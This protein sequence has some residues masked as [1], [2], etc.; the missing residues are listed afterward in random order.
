MRQPIP[1]WARLDRM[2][3]PPPSL[4][5]AAALLLAA[6]GSADAPSS[7][8]SGEP[9]DAQGSWR[10][11]SGRAGGAEI[12]LLD[13][14]PI[15]LTIEG[16]QIGGSSACNTYG[17]RLTVTGG[18][19]EIKDLAMTAMGCE[20]PVM[21][22]EAAYTSA[23]AG[24]DSIGGDG[25]ELVLRGPDVELRF[26]SLAPPPT[27][28]LIDT[29]WVLETVFV[30]DIASSTVGEP[31]TLELRSDGSF[32]GSTGC[33]SFTGSWVE[34]GEQIVAPTM[35]MDGSECPAE[36][37]RQDQQV[38]SVIGDGFVPSVVGN[39]LTLTDP[40]GVGLVYRVEA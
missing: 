11:T 31:A 34:E 26:T 14:R 20:E 19:L 25:D 36:L 5:L 23:L 22:A 8:P 37:S 27:S 33:R 18:R 30:G 4:A 35:A 15:T 21:A 9:F 10:L 2:Q 7:S 39:L 16:S 32:S 13:D 28:D 17:G 40:G 6:C 38:V 3:R 29:T 24:I 1:T 12:P